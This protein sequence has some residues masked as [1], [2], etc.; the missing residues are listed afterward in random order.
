ML[1]SHVLCSHKETQRNGMCGPWIVLQIGL[2]F[3][4]KV[5]IVYMNDVPMIS[6]IAEYCCWHLFPMIVA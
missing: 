4:F 6:G 3:V 5:S 1:G 2:E